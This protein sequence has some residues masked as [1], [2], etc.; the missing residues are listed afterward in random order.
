MA[1]LRENSVNYLNYIDN[2]VEMGDKPLISVI[3]PTHNEERYLGDLLKSIKA[4]TYKNY[5]VIIGDYNSSDKTAKIAKKYGAKFL[6]TTKRG[7]S[8]GRNVGLKIAKGEIIA[9]ID[10]DYILSKKLFHNTVL[11]F[12]KKENQDVVAIEPTTRV[13]N[14]DLNRRDRIKFK[15]LSRLI[16]V[17][18][19]ISYNFDIPAAYGCVFC[20][21]DALFK[22]GN[23]NEDIEICE[24]KELYSRIRKL[25]RFIMIKD[26][27]RMS[28]RRHVKEGTLR[29][30][31]L[32]FYSMMV[33]LIT[34]KFKSRHKPVRGKHD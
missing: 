28:Y 22:A 27:A 16:N 26:T 33:V 23:F 18:K 4:Q 2:S 7:I 10:A 13:N 21:D 17:Y 8:A 34:G 6:R 15:I 3:V 20:R 31:L 29:T 24:D 30:G 19:R 32:Y 25:G 1:K 12:A 11:A 14:K 5:E 9:F